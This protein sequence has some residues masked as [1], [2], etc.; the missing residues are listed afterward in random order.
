ML[1]ATGIGRVAKGHLT[2]SLK[3]IIYFIEIILGAS[4]DDS[5]SYL[6][7]AIGTPIS[8]KFYI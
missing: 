8:G 6:T 4:L 2:V 3:N 5:N 1:K 7:E